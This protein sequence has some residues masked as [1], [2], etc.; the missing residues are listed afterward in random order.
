MDFSQGYF[1]DIYDS[2]DNVM[3]LVF[4]RVIPMI[5]MTLQQAITVSQDVL[6]YVQ[7]FS[8]HDVNWVSHETMLQTNQEIVKADV[9]SF[10]EQSSHAHLLF[11]YF[12][13]E[14][15]L[16]KYPPI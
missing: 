7:G 8:P 1:V 4:L 3:Y 12:L 14:R 5:R 6:H 2:V 16:G 9:N 13:Q 15:W 11:F 10:I